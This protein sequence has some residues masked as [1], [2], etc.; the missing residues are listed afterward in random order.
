MQGVFTEVSR[1]KF[2]VSSMHRSHRVGYAGLVAS[3]LDF[4]RHFCSTT[5]SFIAGS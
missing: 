4:V 2:L 1:L 5:V 3:P